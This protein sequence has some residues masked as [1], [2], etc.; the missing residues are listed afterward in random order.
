MQSRTSRYFIAI[1]QHASLRD[2]AE[3]LRVAQ[4]ALSRQVAKLEYEAGT[5]LFERHPR[6]V[7]LTPAGEVYLRYARDQLA[8]DDHLRAEFESLG[9]PH[10]GTLRIHAIESLARSLLPRVLAAFRQIH[11]GLRFLVT[12]AGSDEIIG[13][14]REVATDIGIG[15]Y[16]QPSPEI[17]IHAVMHEPLVAIMATKHPLARLKQI[18]LRDVSAYPVALTAR[19]SRSRNLIDTACWQAGVS[20]SPML[21]TNSVELLTG[22]VEHSDGVTFLLRISAHD[23]L[24]TRRLGAVPVRSQILNMGAI[25]ALTRTSRKL[26]PVGEEFLAFLGSHLAAAPARAPR[27]RQ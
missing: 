15:Y 7:T 12:I 1:A 21:E 18:G 3:S 11:P 6:G 16:S 25:E 26:P 9:G 14:V 24:R 23:G 27:R 20:F 8:A 17:E 5:K 2:A 22:F 10:R 13:A 19:N 4:S